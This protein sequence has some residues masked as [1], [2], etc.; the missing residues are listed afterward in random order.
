MSHVI[1]AESPAS[2]NPVLFY[3][4]VFILLHLGQQ[5]LKYWAVF[6]QGILMCVAVFVISSK[7]IWGEMNINPFVISAMAILSH[8][9]KQK[10]NEKKRTSIMCAVTTMK[11]TEAGEALCLVSRQAH[12]VVCQFPC[13]SNTSSVS[14]GFYD[15][16]ITFCHRGFFVR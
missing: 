12:V 15:K 4:E 7:I 9:A 3:S 2:K 1:A 11:T 10:R 13:L 8:R 16:I 14:V 6:H 5:Y